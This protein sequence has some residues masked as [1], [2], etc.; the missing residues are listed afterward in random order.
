MED[1]TTYYCFDENRTGL[2][3]NLSKVADISKVFYPNFKKPYYII[4]FRSGVEMKAFLQPPKWKILYLLFW[5]RLKK[6][7]DS[8]L[9]FYENW[10]KIQRDK[11]ESIAQAAEKAAAMSQQIED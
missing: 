1:N 3:I 5:I 10:S 11:A 8:R 9:W 2:K 6:I 7:K 4:T